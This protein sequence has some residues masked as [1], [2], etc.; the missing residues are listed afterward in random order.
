MLRGLESS[1]G[2]KSIAVLDDFQRIRKIGERADLEAERREQLDELD[3]LFAIVG[4]DDQRKF[5]SGWQGANSE[6]GYL[7]LRCSQQLNP[8]F[9]IR[10][11][12]LALAGVGA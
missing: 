4:A 6:C 5:E 9:E 7:K 1:V 3:A 11:P 10:N 2:G 12:K 8:R